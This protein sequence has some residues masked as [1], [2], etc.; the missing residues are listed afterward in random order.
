MTGID[1]TT[2]GA[3]EVQI[4]REIEAIRAD[5]DAQSRSFER[6]LACLDRILQRMESNHLCP[7]SDKC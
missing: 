7:R 3:I 4:L 6:S 1:A 5:L 2:E